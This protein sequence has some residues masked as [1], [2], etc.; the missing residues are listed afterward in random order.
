MADNL[1]SIRE[2][3]KS[4]PVS[5]RDFLSP[6]DREKSE[7]IFDDNFHV[8]SAE[9][10][11]ISENIEKNVKNGTKTVIT[12]GYKGCGKSTFAYYLQKKLP[13]RGYTIDFE[14]NVD[15]KLTT[16]GP[17]LQDICNKIKDDIFKD[18]QVTNKLLSVLYKD[19]RNFE[20]LN[21]GFDQRGVFFAFFRFL[22]NKA[23]DINLDGSFIYQLAA[24]LNKNYVI[25]DLFSIIILWDIAVRLV[26]K[27]KN[28]RIFMILDNLDALVKFAP[29]GKLFDDYYIARNNCVN[30]FMKIDYYS[31]G[32]NKNPAHDYTFIFMLRET[33]LAIIIEHFFDKDKTYH[34]DVYEFSTAIPKEEIISRR[35]EYAKKDSSIKFSID[36]I[37]DDLHILSKDKLIKES[38]FCLFNDDYRKSIDA[39]L[40]SLESDER[41]LFIQDYFSIKASY[42]HNTSVG[43]GGFFIRILCDLFFEKKCF[44]KLLFADGSI[45]FGNPNSSINISRLI[46]TFLNN[47]ANQSKSSNL[48]V[49][50]QNILDAFDGL[51]H[52]DQ[53]INQKTV[54]NAVWYLFEL[55]KE[56]F[57]NHLITF[58]KLSGLDNFQDHQLDGD[59]LLRNI[60]KDSTI[61]ITPA[62]I[63]F[64][65][66][67]LTHFEYYSCRLKMSTKKTLPLFD[68]KNTVFHDQNNFEFDLI[69][70]STIDFVKECSKK[71]KT[72]YETYFIGKR[73]FNDE[74][75]LK[76]NFSYHINNGENNESNSMFHIERVIHSH[77]DYLDV[78][79]RYVINLLADEYQK[80]DANE[81]II[82]YIKQYMQMFGYY[83]KTPIT[84][85]SKQSQVLCGYYDN[86]VQKIEESDFADFITP[87]DRKTGREIGIE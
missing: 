18:R 58:D 78:Y 60:N 85:S 74:S 11:K 34:P 9:A 52:P 59:I 79:R 31:L 37:I 3:L 6:E 16:R 48:T 30:L 83:N 46:L 40:E 32:F 67:I 26:N 22:E 65:D 19:R 39:L 53:F 12:K 33:T 81:R 47:H 25:A 42:P 21:C 71:L 15:T 13:F 70:Q 49:S 2:F 28:K 51:I 57:W 44:N 14:M 27:E 61:G 1:N 66:N 75:F 36:T 43:S 50:I 10:E 56:T 24:L 54:I 8:N 82:N 68:K 64:L 62:G 69:I 4:S 35:L 63:Y 76:S 7:Q 29:I 72:H 41:K 77:I 17:L 87:I 20:C 45:A 5:L 84:H 80:K 55:R 23:R 38:L 73:G 86:C